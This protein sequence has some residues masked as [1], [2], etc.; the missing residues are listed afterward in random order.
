MLIIKELSFYIHISDTKLRRQIPLFAY[1]SNAPFETLVK[2]IWALL[3]IIKKEFQ[4]QKYSMLS[5]K[6]YMPFHFQ[7]KP[8]AQIV[9]CALIIKRKVRG[10]NFRN[11]KFDQTHAANH[12]VSLKATYPFEILMKKWTLWS[13]GKK[14]V[15][16]EDLHRQFHHDSAQ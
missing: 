12:N 9:M 11:T 7:W 3:L 13:F 8:K 1:K 6:S 10:K 15:G 16:D 2:N 4:T 14:G 5:Q